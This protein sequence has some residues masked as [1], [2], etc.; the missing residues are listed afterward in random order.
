MKKNLMTVVILALLIVNL[1]LTGIIMFFTVSANQKTIALVND[2]ASVLDLELNGGVG[3]EAMVTVP[4]ED[5]SV[6]NIEDAMTIA[7]K[8]DADGTDHYALVSVSFSLNMKDPDYETYEP[9]MSEKESK[10]KSEIIDVVG[11]YTK[12]EAMSDESGLEEAILQRVQTMFNSKFV[13]EAYFR[14]IKF[15]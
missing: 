3:E 10:I 7:L 1:A 9:M 15:Q 8:Q 14:D 6:Y 13:Y 5:T 2:I 4:I 11:S 12:E